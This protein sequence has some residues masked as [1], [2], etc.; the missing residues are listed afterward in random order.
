MVEEQVTA[1]VKAVLDR[2]NDFSCM[3]CA[4]FAFPFLPMKSLCLLKELKKMR[5]NHDEIQVKSACASLELDHMFVNRA[6]VLLG[7][8][9]NNPLFIGQFFCWLSFFAGRCDRKHILNT[10]TGI[11]EEDDNVEK[12]G[13]IGIQSAEYCITALYLLVGPVKGTIVSLLNELCEKRKACESECVWEDSDDDENKNEKIETVQW[14]LS[15]DIPEV[16]DVLTPKLSALFPVIVKQSYLIQPLARAVEAWALGPT[17]FSKY[18]QDFILDSF[19]K[20]VVREVDLRYFS[21]KKR[22]HLAWRLWKLSSLVTRGWD[23]D[24]NSI[25]WSEF[26]P[27]SRKLVQDYYFCIPQ[28]SS[29]VQK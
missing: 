21:W 25:F 10:N 22:R 23:N 1:L 20:G 18:E 12:S 7:K 11:E 15:R 26:S 4:E 28:C 16:Q 2:R 6:S 24:I 5:H 29:E 27:R 17:F 14:C 8:E 3:D 19:K 9:T 13:K